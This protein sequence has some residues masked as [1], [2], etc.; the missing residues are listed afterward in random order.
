MPYILAE[1]SQSI[2]RLRTTATEFSLVS[3]RSQSTWMQ[4]VEEVGEGEPVAQPVR[5][6]DFIWLFV[7]GYVKSEVYHIC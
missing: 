1:R 3:F 2:V 7:W 5:L 4:I 6:Q